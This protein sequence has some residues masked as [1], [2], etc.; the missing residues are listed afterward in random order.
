MVIAWSRRIRSLIRY[1]LAIAAVAAAFL[2]RLALT[3][4]AG[5]ELPT[6][7]TFYPAIMAVALLGGLGPGLVATLTTALAVDY[8]ILPPIGTLF[9]YVSP[10]DAVGEALFTSMGLFIC[11]VADLY[12]RNRVKAAQYDKEL[13]LTASL[14]RERQVLQSVMNGARNAHLVYLDPAFNF[15]RVNETY[16][17]SCG[18]APEEMIG[19][20]HFA[21]YPDKE[22]EAIFARV[23]DTGAPAEFH[24]KPFVFPD[25]PERGLTYWDWTLIPIK[26]PSGKVEG[27]VFS[28]VETTERKRAEEAVK[29]A[30]AEAQEGRRSLQKVKEEWER[31]FD[32]VPDLIAILDNDH[33]IVR[34]NKAMADRLGMAAA[35][36]AGLPCYR[37]VHG[38]E[39]PPRFCPHVLTLADGGQHVAEVHEDRLGGDFLVSTTPLHDDQ[40]RLIGSVHVARDITLLKKSEDALRRLTE[41]L[42]RSNRDLEEF[43]H[44]ISHNLKEPLRMVTGFMGLLKERY[45][46]KLDAKADEYIAFAADAAT[47]MQRLIDDLLAFS[48]V[49]RGGSI[50]A[51]SVA[52]A[53]DEAIQNL[54]IGIEESGA[55]ITR[56]SLPVVT[57]NRMELTQLF[58]NLIGN[59]L[60]FR[61]EGVAPEIHMGARR[62]SEEEYGGM[63]VS[64]HGSE[65][66]GLKAENCTLKVNTATAPISQTPI[67]PHDPHS[68]HWLF[69]VRDNGI[70]ID[71]SYHERIFVIFQRLHTREDYPGTGV[72]LAICKKIVER[73]GGRIWVESEE[74]KGSTFWF[75]IPV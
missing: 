24:D 47:R 18:Y 41:D 60:K 20:N 27:L 42:A 7:I 50:G 21:L 37:C 70:G 49:G 58:Q 74:G 38:A 13:V 59:A 31:T 36:C 39:G 62:V 56:D 44:A 48:R 43:A 3:A 68:P 26:K 51:V 66:R 12:R 6:Y 35:Q 54:R 29:T 32:N 69:S 2:L 61:R 75:T 4:Y 15:V 22:N 5:G 53:V 46:G 25:Q 45:G 40:G 30:L 72:G 73:H 71:P 65:K 9:T 16:A 55:R 10:A 57:A 8:W 67:H 52:D 28:L 14:E 19:K 34:V 17:K 23:R 11:V 63:G 33:G 1:G 64:A